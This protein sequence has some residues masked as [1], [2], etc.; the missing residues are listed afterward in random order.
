MPANTITRFFQQH[1]GL[2][3]SIGRLLMKAHLVYL[4]YPVDPSPRYGHGKAPHEKLYAL[5]DSR[6][7]EYA[8]SLA[9]FRRYAG[10]LERIPTTD[11][12]EGYNGPSWANG[13]LPGLDA[14][15]IYCFLSSLNPGR[16]FEI[17]SGQSTRFARKAIEDHGLRTRITSI[18]PDPRAKIDLICDRVVRMPL[19]ELELSIFDELEEGDVLFVDDGHRALMNYG[20]TVFFLDV[21]PELADG[22]LLAVHDVYLPYDYPPEWERLYYSEQYLLASYLLAGCGWLEVAFPAFFVSQ[23]PDLSGSIADLWE[24]PNIRGAERHG[25]AFWMRISRS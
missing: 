13:Y 3:N 24:R 14:V 1:L 22:I 25:G 11:P 7:D 21:L 20:P 4:D 12:G 23:D 15:A 9:V 17:G 8:G 10:D 16:Y 2:V 19:Q 6:R 5:V 18:D